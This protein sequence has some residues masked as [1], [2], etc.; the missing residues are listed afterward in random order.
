MLFLTLGS[1]THYNL[2]RP[3]KI[4][5]FV[6]RCDSSPKKYYLHNSA[7]KISRITWLEPTCQ[8]GIVSDIIFDNVFKGLVVGCDTTQLNGYYLVEKCFPTD[9]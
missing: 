5:R 2:G 9:S 3:K 4:K 7:M 6:P 8:F 1:D